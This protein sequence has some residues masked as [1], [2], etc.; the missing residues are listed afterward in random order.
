MCL[1]GSFYH[2]HAFGKQSGYGLTS[3]AP[4]VLSKAKKK[5][6]F[7]RG[8]GCDP[9]EDGEMKLVIKSACSGNIKKKC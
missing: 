6:A 4:R 3:H 1:N 9:N 8:R 5:H 2:C 7:G